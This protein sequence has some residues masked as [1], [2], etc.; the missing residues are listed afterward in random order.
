[1]GLRALV[2]LAALCALT[3]PLFAQTVQPQGAT[4]RRTGCT[5]DDGTLTSLAGGTPV[6]PRFALDGNCYKV[7][8]T[9]EGTAVEGYLPATAI[10]GM[11]SYEKA[12]RSAR[13]VVSAS[14]EPA[15]AP[16]ART[17]SAA[18]GGGNPVAR[19]AALMET[20]MGLDT[21]PHLPNTAL[22][23]IIAPAPVEFSVEKP[24][25]RPLAARTNR[26]PERCC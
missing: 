16:A 26:W 21:R 4:L 11:E 23:T 12:R 5:E 17:A 2:R 15:T 13:A 22:R 20:R 1:M 14:P 3:A 18:A 9:L 24:W 6:A 19:A 7:A 10:A 25:H 8:V